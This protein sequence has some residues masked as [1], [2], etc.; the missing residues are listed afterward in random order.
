MEYTIREARVEDGGAAARIYAPYVV[1]TAITFEEQPPDAPEMSRRIGD[2]LAGHP[3][4]VAESAGA[5]IGYAYATSHR[6]RASYRWSADV[7]VYLD[8]NHHHCGVGSAMYGVLLPL[9]AAQGFVMAHAGVTLP[10]PASV[11]LHEAVG[12]KPVG[13]FR[14]VGYKL[15]EWRDVGWWAKQL[16]N[17]RPQ[18]DEPIAWAMM[19]RLKPLL[20]R[21]RTA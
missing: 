17:P 19:P 8:G 16:N 15:G 7:S 5:V 11:G 13:I 21:K 18:P 14:N 2:T 3:F 6:A 10:N 1:E 20:F 9:L 4:L 12:F